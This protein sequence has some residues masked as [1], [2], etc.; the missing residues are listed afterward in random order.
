MLRVD[1]G[2]QVRQWLI[3]AFEPSE[4]AAADPWATADSLQNVLLWPTTAPVTV[5]D[6]PLA[7][8]RGGLVTDSSLRPRVSAVIGPGAT[9]RG[10]ATRLLPIYGQVPGAATLAAETLARA[11]VVYSEHYLPASTL[12]AYR[13]GLRLPLPIEIDQR[14]GAWIVNRS[15]VTS[16]ASA[17]DPSWQ[18]GLDRRPAH[19][20][21]AEPADVATAATRFLGEHPDTLGRAVALQ[22]RLLTNPFADVFLLLEVLRRLGAGVFDV[23]LELLDQTVNHQALLLATLTAGNGALRV[24]SSVLDAAP[25]GLSASRAASVARARTMLRLALGGGGAP[26]TPR[27]LPA[28][29]QQLTPRPGNVARHAPGADPVAGTHALALG[30]DVALGRVGTFTQADGTAFRG[31]AFAGRLSPT[32]FIASHA[33]ELNPTNDP[34]LDARLAI[35][36]AIAP[37]EGMLDAIRMQDRGILSLGMQQWS[38]HADLELPSLLHRWRQAAPDE[39]ALHAGVHRLGVRAAGASFRL[40]EVAANASASDLVSHADRVTFFGGTT[41][42]ALTTFDNAWAARLREA[43]LSSLSLRLAQVL[44]GAG[45]FDRLRRDVGTLHVAGAVV[46]VE[47]LITSQLGAAALLDAHINQPG[48]VRADLQA[49]VNAVGPQPNPDALERAVVADYLTRRHTQNT[50]ARNATIVAAHLDPAHGSFTGW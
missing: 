28:T 22:A 44:E 27:E 12:A 1:P 9:L 34:R 8:L 46:P 43:V 7:A 11:L 29:A 21:Q 10:V 25:A 30:R 36:R 38:A 41:A 20:D 2:E 15:L 32:P 16:W 39:F 13:D 31:V 4:Q 33:A 35:V 3:E 18:P 5:R 23:V 40:Q 45:R 17:F 19:L 50:P 26:P 24:L 6:E 37:N 47:Q 48:H 42:G 14:D 49:S